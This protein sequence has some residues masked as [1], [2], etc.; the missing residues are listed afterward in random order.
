[1]RGWGRTVVDLPS[2]LHTRG[3]A[4]VAIQESAP[5]LRERVF[6]CIKNYGPITDEDIATTARIA[7][8]T[9]RPRRLELERAG[10][11]V[12]AGTTKTR[13]GRKAVTWEAAS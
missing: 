10:R 3:E 5:S 13:S 12:A 7:P 8:N 1:M 9:A 4:E 11:I 2:T 6:L